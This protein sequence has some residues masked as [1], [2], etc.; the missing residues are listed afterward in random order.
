VPTTTGTGSLSFTAGGFTV[1]D[2][3][4]HKTLALALALALAGVFGRFTIVLA[5]AAVNAVAMHLRLFGHYLARQAGEQTSGG[6]GYCG[7]SDAYC[8]FTDHGISSRFACA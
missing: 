3:H 2:A 1:G 7:A 6:Q 4:I 5:F 8:G